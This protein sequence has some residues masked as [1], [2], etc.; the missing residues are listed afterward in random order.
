MADD[1]T[2]HNGGPGDGSPFDV[3]TD[4]DGSGNHVQL[5]KLVY[6]G[7]GSRTAIGADANG[8]DVDV[9]RYPKGSKTFSDP[10]P[11]NTADLVLAANAS[12]ISATIQNV[13]AIGVYLG[14]DNTVTTATGLYLPAGGSIVDD[15]STDA[16]W[17]I[18]SSGTADLRVCEVA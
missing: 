6:A 17:A 14:K 2:V 3:A 9:V 1:V 18:T 7:D 11:D 8:L 4:D 15:V 10:A 5:I 12:R 13:G 16:W